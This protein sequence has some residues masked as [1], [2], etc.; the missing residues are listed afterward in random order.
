M[1]PS[2][3]SNILFVPGHVRAVASELSIQSHR[4][5]GIVTHVPYTAKCRDMPST[6]IRWSLLALVVSIV[7]VVSIAVVVSIVVV[8]S[9]IAFIV[10]IIVVVAS[11]VLVV[12]IIVLLVSAIVSVASIIA[13]ASAIVLDFDHQ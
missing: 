12:F 7:L 4:P 10:S 9:I 5:R 1:V 6:H 11:I 8:V 3:S 13:V 2:G